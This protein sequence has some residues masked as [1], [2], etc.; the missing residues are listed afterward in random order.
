MPD[1]PLIARPATVRAAIDAHRE[2]RKVLVRHPRLFGVK[3]VNE[4]DA[5][6]KVPQNVLV[7]Y[8]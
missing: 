6:L 3:F 5:Q 7:S 1:K 8:W 4:H 2:T